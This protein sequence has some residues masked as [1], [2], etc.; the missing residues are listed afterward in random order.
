MKEKR[1]LEEWRK[2]KV[3]I[4]KP[5]FAERAQSREHRV[6]VARGAKQAV[7]KVL[8]KGSGS[9]SLEDMSN[10]I[11]SNSTK[12]MI[13][14]AGTISDKDSL[15]K[16]RADWMQD[17]ECGVKRARSIDFVHVALSVP[18]GEDREV[19]ERAA[20]SMMHDYFPNRRWMAARHNDTANPHVHVIIQNRDTDNKPLPLRKADLLDYREQWVSSCRAQGIQVEA[21]L[22]S[23]RGQTIKSKNMAMVQL[24]ERGESLHFEEARAVDGHK[25][26]HAI[27]LA[28]VESLLRAAKEF[29]EEARVSTKEQ[30]KEKKYLL[31]HSKKLIKQAKML[32]TS[33]TLQAR[34]DLESKNISR[35]VP[36]QRGK[37]A[38]AE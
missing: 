25:V 36:K 34:V 12:E 19:T 9:R 6:A 22:R 37:G 2:G 15:I 20:V 28:R 30:T 31:N 38:V 8:S 18:A 10:Y 7:F 3:R 13:T 32:A 24:H 5:T 17:F 16:L 11:S 29:A 33:D 4:E 23:E 21:I 26:S 27:Q 35:L 1:F 14:E